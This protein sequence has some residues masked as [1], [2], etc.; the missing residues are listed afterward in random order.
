MILVYFRCSEEPS[1]LN[2][3]LKQLSDYR[4]KEYQPITIRP[5]HVLV[6]ALRA[7]KQPSFR[8]TKTLT[9]ILQVSQLFCLDSIYITTVILGRLG[10]AGLDTNLSADEESNNECDD[11]LRQ[12]EDTLI[13]HAMEESKKEAQP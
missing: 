7:A 13:E 6:D 4:Y 3:L 2:V 1:S 11:D 8:S 12:T 5:S 10:T 9:V